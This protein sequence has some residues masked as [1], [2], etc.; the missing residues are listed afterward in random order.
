MTSRDVPLVMFARVMM[1]ATALVLIPTLAVAAGTLDASVSGTVTDAETGLPVEGATIGINIEGFLALAETDVMGAYLSEGLPA[2]DAMM[3]IDATGYELFSTNF[4]IGEGESVVVD[5]TLQPTPLAGVVG[6]V[7]DSETTEPLV[8]VGLTLLEG[9][10]C[11]QDGTVLHLAD[12]DGS[13]GF[14]FDDVTPGPALLSATSTG[15]KDFNVELT[16]VE[17]EGANLVLVPL[18]PADST[19]ESPICSAAPPDE[20]DEGAELP[21]TGV[22]SGALIGAAILMSM[23]GA[24]L[25]RRGR[26]QE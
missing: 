25:L 21:F 26:A 17:G 1:L 23:A 13:G 11:T 7:F 8:G 20:V 14:T 18:V 10:S 22:S 6:E 4:V 15:Y 24:L 3:D 9:A 16:L 5:A 2:G 12:S 19:E